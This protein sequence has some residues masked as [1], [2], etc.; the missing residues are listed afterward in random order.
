MVTVTTVDEFGELLYSQPG[1]G[2][3]GDNYGV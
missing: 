3:V 1:G 2:D